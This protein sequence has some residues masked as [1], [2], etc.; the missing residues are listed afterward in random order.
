M[1]ATKKLR[2]TTSCLK[3]RRRAAVRR[4]AVAAPFPLFVLSARQLPSML[5]GIG[6]QSQRVFF[7][8]K[9]NSK[10]TSVPKRVKEQERQR[11]KYLHNHIIIDQTGEAIIESNKNEHRVIFDFLKVTFQF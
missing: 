9:K 1:V 4:A 2:S 8:K 10:E 6:G 11:G 5:T 3:H 7:M